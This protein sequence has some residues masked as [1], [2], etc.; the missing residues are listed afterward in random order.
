MALSWPWAASSMAFP[1]KA[2]RRTA[3]SASKTPAACRAEYSPR[4]RPAAA[5]GVIPLSRSTAVTPTAKATMQ[6]WVYRV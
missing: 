5:E 2:T 1:R 4:E 6:G 3:V